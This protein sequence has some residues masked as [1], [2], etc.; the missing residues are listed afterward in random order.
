MPPMRTLKHVDSIEYR[1]A[2][3]SEMRLRA[4]NRLYARRAAV[5]ALIRSL[6]LYEKTQQARK[7]ACVSITSERK[8]S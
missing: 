7:A 6:E 1:P 2:P 5:D 8:C 4:L 3:I